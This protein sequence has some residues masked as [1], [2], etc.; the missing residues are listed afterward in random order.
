[1]TSLRTLCFCIASCRHQEE[2]VEIQHS[3]LFI[4]EFRDIYGQFLHYCDSEEFIL[5]SDI[6]TGII[7][8]RFYYSCD[9]GCF[10]T[11][12]L[13]LVNTMKIPGTLTSVKAVLEQQQQQQLL[14]MFTVTGQI[15]P[16]NN[17]GG[18][19]HNTDLY[20]DY[21]HLIRCMQIATNQASSCVFGLNL[22]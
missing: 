2:S 9:V 15:S 4:L 11:T 13:P 16:A 22:H 21:L 7:L 12:V 8:H 19:Q 1:M 17:P 5:Q 14:A 20:T 10:Y 6:T 3:P 18:H